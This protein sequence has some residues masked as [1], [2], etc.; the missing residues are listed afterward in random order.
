MDWVVISAVAE[1]TAAFGVI[2]SLIFVG[3]QV[4]QN[5]AGLRYAAV[6]TQLSSTQDLAG[7]LALSSEVAE[8]YQQ[9]TYDIENMEGTS[10]VRFLILGSRMLRSFQS[11][12]WMWQRGVLDD[13]LFRSQSVL[14]E[15]IVAYPGYQYLWKLRRHQYDTDFQH[16]MDKMFAD[17]K[18]VPL[19]VETVAKD[20]G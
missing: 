1:A 4:K 14:L 10:R 9:G 13:G 17:G 3:Y 2:G 20:A 5:S 19:Y 11:V 12:H 7:E 8:I 6:Q 16:Y 18:G 15:D